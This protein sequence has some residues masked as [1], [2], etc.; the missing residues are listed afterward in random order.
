MSKK[1]PTLVVPDHLN[2]NV[3]NHYKQIL[4]VYC[5]FNSSLNFK[6]LCTTPDDFI[7]KPSHGSIP[8][9]SSVHILIQKK[10]KQDKTIKNSKLLIE[11]YDTAKTI[12]GNRVIHVDI[13]KKETNT[14]SPKISSNNISLN[15]DLLHE[16]SSSSSKSQ[17]IKEKD[18]KQQYNL[19]Q[20]ILPL[21]L[22]SIF[23][24]Y[25]SQ[26]HMNPF[27]SYFDSIWIAY[28]IG[29]ITMYYQIKLFEK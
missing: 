2:L 19:L 21:T 28:F 9:Q 25:I 4:T 15:N 13:D 27:D 23:I 11:T 6:V 29:M 24:T 12:K 1:V 18:N 3:N 10:N 14:K 5:P 8:S 20:K 22:S 17:D 26:D 16:T 7:I